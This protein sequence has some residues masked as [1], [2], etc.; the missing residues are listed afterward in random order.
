M[1]EISIEYNAK[2]AEWGTSSFTYL[3]QNILA[4]YLHLEVYYCHNRPCKFPFSLAHLIVKLIYYHRNVSQWF[5]VDN[6]RTCTLPV[7]RL[8]IFRHCMDSVCKGPPL[9]H[10][11]NNN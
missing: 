7:R 6:D 8:H 3:Q 11:K 5:L 9:K 4:N 2:N 10:L 1:I